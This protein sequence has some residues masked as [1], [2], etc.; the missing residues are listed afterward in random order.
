MKS[1]FLR[2]NVALYNG[3]MRGPK[4]SRNSGRDEAGWKGV[5]AGLGVSSTI[6]SL[7]VRFLSESFGRSPCALKRRLRGDSRGESGGT[8]DKSLSRIS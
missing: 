4:Q 3:Y 7:N 8:P 2:S 6:A 5:R 1:I